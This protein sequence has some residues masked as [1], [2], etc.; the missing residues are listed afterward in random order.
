MTYKLSYLPVDC[1]LDSNHL[2]IFQRWHC[3]F[4][5]KSYIFNVQKQTAS[6]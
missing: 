6:L 5:L 4:K 1:F 2:C 3:A